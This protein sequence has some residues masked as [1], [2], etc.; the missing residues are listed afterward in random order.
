M[1]RQPLSDAGYSFT[2]IALIGAVI[3]FSLLM[4]SLFIYPSYFSGKTA[5]AGFKQVTD[6]PVLASDVTGYADLSG[7]LGSVTVA[8]SRPAPSR[9]GAVGMTIK[10]D[11][12]RMEWQTGTGV[13]L[14]Q[15]Q[16]IFNTPSGS[17][18]LTRL[19][20]VPYTKPGWAI[21]SKGS[22]LANGQANANDILEPNEA[23]GI[24]V[25]PRTPLSPDTPF[26]V[27]IRMQDENVLTVNRT[28]P[29]QIT[30]VMDLG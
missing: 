13:D 20:A 1:H 6:N 25:Y 24:F 9:L 19:S 22:T 18:T 29:A 16:V 14:D 27:I 7:R 3:I 17:E 21:V 10:L 8:N 23:F 30:P 15:T 5:Y 11:S 4:F 26:S 2:F 12:V 28:V